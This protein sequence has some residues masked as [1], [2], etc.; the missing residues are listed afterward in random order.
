VNL[1]LA[2]FLELVRDAGDDDRKVI[3]AVKRSARR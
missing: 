1:T 3:E 2:Q